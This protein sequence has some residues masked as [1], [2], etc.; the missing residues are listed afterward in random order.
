MIRLWKATLSLGISVLIV[1]E[2]WDELR[3]DR[4]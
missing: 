1:K 4:A 3:G 2:A